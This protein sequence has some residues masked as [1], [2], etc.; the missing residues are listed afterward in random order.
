MLKPPPPVPN[1]SPATPSKGLPKGCVIAMIVA[2]ALAVIAIPVIAIL[3]SLAIPAMNRT[4]A[5][6]KEVQ[7]QSTAAQLEVAIESYRAEYAK[8]PGEKAG[9]DLTTESRGRLLAT[10]TGDP[11]EAGPA[12]WNP[13]QVAFY[14]VGVASTQSDPSIQLDPWG[15]VY[16]IRLDTDENNGIEDPE[17]GKI[18]P[19]RV[20]IWSAGP[21]GQEETWDDNVK[22]WE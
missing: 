19:A 3:A 9:E 21:D 15:N 11:S 16:R 14:I 13:R 1:P 18:I 7:A 6:A 17:T 12:G 5:R 2:A 8:Y 4:V 20:L 22:S 10:L